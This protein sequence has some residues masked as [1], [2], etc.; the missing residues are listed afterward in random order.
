MIVDQS[1]V[2]HIKSW[3]S[4]AK[5]TGITNDGSTRVG[6]D[7]F[8]LDQ[9]WTTRNTVPAVRC[10][11][12]TIDWESALSN[13]LHSSSNTCCTRMQALMTEEFRSTLRTLGRL[14]IP[15]YA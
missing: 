8:T 14:D 13:R 6:N 11:S 4:T 2:P 10:S 3:D 1:I 7:Y 12:G 9:E 15:P 5:E